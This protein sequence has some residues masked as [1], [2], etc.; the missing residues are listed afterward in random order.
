MDKHLEFLKKL[1]E[2]IHIYRMNSPSDDFDAWLWD[3][4]ESPIHAK[5][6]ELQKQQIEVDKQKSNINVSSV[7]KRA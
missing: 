3:E 6:I 4:V 5:S 1:R 2:A 7:I